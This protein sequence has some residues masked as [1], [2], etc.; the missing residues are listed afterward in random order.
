M[1]FNPENDTNFILLPFKI[2]D[3]KNSHEVIQ[4]IQKHHKM[5]NKRKGVMHMVKKKI[6]LHYSFYCSELAKQV[7]YKNRNN[8]QIRKDSLQPQTQK[9][10]GKKNN[11]WME[12][13][14]K[15]LYEATLKDSLFIECFFPSVWKSTRFPS[16][17]VNK[18]IL[19]YCSVSDNDFWD[20]ISPSYNLRPFRTS[21][22]AQRFSSLIRFTSTEG[23]QID[24]KI[25]T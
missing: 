16:V 18:C 4:N 22:S 6:K 17:I 25:C 3:C 23:E 9:W 19:D 13:K 21:Y 5:Y 15:E 10:K 8:K 14:A 12:F 24:V 20:L 11:V 2:K 7:T 1:R